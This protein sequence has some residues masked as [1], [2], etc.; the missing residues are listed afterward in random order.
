ME[1]MHKS[2]K[3]VLVAAALVVVAS[4]GFGL[5]YAQTPE[6]SVAD[7]A[8]TTE[9]HQRLN[10]DQKLQLKEL[11]LAGDRDGVMALME[12]WGV[13]KSFKKGQGRHMKHGFQN[14]LTDAQR[15]LARETHEKVMSGELTHEEAQGLLAAEG[16]DAPEISEEK[17]EKMKV[18]HEKK[19][20]VKAVMESGDY[21]AWLTTM[22]ENFPDAPFMDDMTE[23]KF[24]VMQE[25]HVAREAGDKELAKS[26]AEEAGFEL[27]MGKRKGHVQGMRHEFID[28]LTDEQKEQVE[29]AK[30]SGDREGVRELMESFKAELE[31]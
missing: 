19:E 4:T 30:T 23:E 8:S 1:K 27:K 3:S 13:E 18:M 31:S 5:T 14:D 24:E 10:D 17:L 2:N 6:V 20:V 25:I 26:L 15:E 9:Q 29:A 12:E 11:H 7:A 16:I 21:Q 22:E 28:A